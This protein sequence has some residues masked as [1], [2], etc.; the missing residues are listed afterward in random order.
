MLQSRRRS[1]LGRAGLIVLLAGLTVLPAIATTG[2]A[3]SQDR[4]PGGMPLTP[5][6]TPQA[7][8]QPLPPAARPAAPI[9][10]ARAA[11]GMC[12]CISDHDRRHISCLASVEECQAACA[13]SK[14]SFV[15]NA[16]NCP[17]TAQGR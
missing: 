1:R 4:R 12:Q 15:P 8:P 16:P 10:P 13:A 3:A 17:A 5:A 6:A 14:Y 9:I 11:T 7:S 2:L